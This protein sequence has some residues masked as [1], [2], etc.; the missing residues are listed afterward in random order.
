METP[1]GRFAS[2]EPVFVVGPLERDPTR[3]RSHSAARS[4]LEA[5]MK[6]YCATRAVACS[7]G[8]TAAH[9]SRGLLTAVACAQGQKNPLQERCGEGA[10]PE[11]DLL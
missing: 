7:C 4:S 6:R 5:Y 10:R 1:P 2:T 8:H 3:K 9:C 11:P